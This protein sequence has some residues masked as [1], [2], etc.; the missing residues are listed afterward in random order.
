MYN[1]FIKTSD[2]KIHKYKESMQWMSS[3]TFAEFLTDVKAKNPK[4]KYIESWRSRNGN[5]KKINKN[6]K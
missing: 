3:D 6:T 2:K 1:Y 5:K 4:A